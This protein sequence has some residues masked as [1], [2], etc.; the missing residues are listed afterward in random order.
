MLIFKW[1]SSGSS[2]PAKISG[3]P[4]GVLGFWLLIFFT[5]SDLVS[6][7]SYL[8]FSIQS[9]LKEECHCYNKSKGHCFGH[10][11]QFI[12]F[13]SSANLDFFQS[14]QVVRRPA[15]MGGSVVRPQKH[16]RIQEDNQAVVPGGSAQ[17][18]SCHFL[19]S[20]CSNYEINTSRN[21]RAVLYIMQVQ[22]HWR[23]GHIYNNHAHFRKLWTWGCSFFHL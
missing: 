5:R 2:S 13:F 19:F 6:S 7:I 11:S 4:R 22:S 9:H 15:V 20:K 17:T 3:A 12:T 18:L 16:R 10:L 1:H 21:M 8:G 14:Q 23:R